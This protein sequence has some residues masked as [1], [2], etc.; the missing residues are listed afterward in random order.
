MPRTDLGDTL[1][2][3][4]PQPF[5][6]PFDAPRCFCLSFH[7]TSGSLHR[8]VLLYRRT[9]K[10][11]SNQLS[12]K[13]CIWAVGGQKRFQDWSKL[14]SSFSAIDT[15]KLPP[16]M[17]RAS[18]DLPESSCIRRVEGALGKDACTFPSF[19]HINSIN[20][21]GSLSHDPIRVH[22]TTKR[23]VRHVFCA[24]R[25]P[26]ITMQARSE[27]PDHQILNANFTSQRR[28]M[29]VTVLTK[30]DRMSQPLPLVEQ[31][32]WGTGLNSLVGDR[33][34]RTRQEIPISCKMT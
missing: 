28:D 17:Q 26:D 32:E 9:G 11:P 3:D 21:K 30:N 7:F 27:N 34:R 1:E 19:R 4:Q 10:E 5:Y 6:A 13:I 15:D 2:L 23:A 8:Y 18:H 22:A 24:A 20:E 33:N 31:R 25:S 14:S 29:L 16:R 12:Y